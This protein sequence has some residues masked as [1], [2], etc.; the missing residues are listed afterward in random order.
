MSIDRRRKL[1]YA[2]TP[3]AILN[4]RIAWRDQQQYSTWIQQQPTRQQQQQERKNS[5]MQRQDTKTRCCIVNNFHRTVQHYKYNQSLSTESRRIGNVLY[6]KDLRCTITVSWTI[7]IVRYCDCYNQLS[8]TIS[9][10][11]YHLHA[12][13]V[14]KGV[15]YQ[16][17]QQHQQQQRQNN[18]NRPRAASSSYSY[19]STKNT[20]ARAALLLSSS[21]LYTPSKLPDARSSNTQR[22]SLARHF[23][24]QYSTQIARAAQIRSSISILSS[25]SLSV[26]KHHWPSSIKISYISVSHLLTKQ[27][28][29]P[30]WI[31]IDHHQLKSVISL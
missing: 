17:W 21:L 29:L 6:C 4:Q 16:C 23:Q 3:A 27:S 26:L 8:W 9:V 10:K 12:S 25:T 1:E 15:L 7:S 28:C 13:T 20:G 11:R 18:A 30:Y 5:T 24:Q 22:E 31:T 2:H 14:Y 19:S